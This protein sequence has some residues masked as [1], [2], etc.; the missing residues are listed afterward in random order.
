MAKQSTSKP[1]P[2]LSKPKASLTGS[3]KPARPKVSLTSPRK[4]RVGTLT[5]VG[6]LRP[7]A[8]VRKKKRKPGV[9]SFV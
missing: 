1:K 2:S 7:T 5:R 4:K 3:R 6:T 9:Q 8:S